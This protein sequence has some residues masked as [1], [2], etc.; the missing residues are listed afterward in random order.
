MSGVNAAFVS[1]SPEGHPYVARVVGLS[2]KFGLDREFLASRKLDRQ[3]AASHATLPGL[4]EV[5][6]ADWR[7]TVK[8]YYLLT[9]VAGEQVGPLPIRDTLAVA[10]ATELERGRRIEDLIL[11]RRNGKWKVRAED[12]ALQWRAAATTAAESPSPPV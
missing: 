5:A 2:A 3:R 11:R 10:I 8:A 1:C 12:G 6:E 4:Y 9:L 7:R